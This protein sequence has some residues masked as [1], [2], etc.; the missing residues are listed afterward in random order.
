MGKADTV[1]ST[2]VVKETDAARIQFDALDWLR[3]EQH[4]ANNIQYAERG[5]IALGSNPNLSLTSPATSN[6]SV[7]PNST[8]SKL[9]I[10]PPGNYT[11]CPSPGVPGG[12]HHPSGN[13]TGPCD[14]NQT[15]FW[16]HPTGPG[17]PHSRPTIITTVSVTQM[18]ETLSDGRHQNSNGPVITIKQSGQT[19]V[20]PLPLPGGDEVERTTPESLV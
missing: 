16:D 9:C 5:G 8:S 13:Y 20:I 7:S 11:G 12:R 3:T 6:P 14:H 19:I 2:G 17:G 4:L 10:W 18:T 15:K 1:T